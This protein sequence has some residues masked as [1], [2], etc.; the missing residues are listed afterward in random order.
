LEKYKITD[1]QDPADAIP[2]SFELYQNYPN[3]FNPTTT[4]SY[5]ILRNGF[6]SLIVYDALGR[7]VQTLVNEEKARGKYSFVFDASSLPSGVYFYTLRAGEF[8]S[9]KKLMLIK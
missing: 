3:P 2:L 8:I 9:T 7:K 4:I 5:Q 6:V 1:V